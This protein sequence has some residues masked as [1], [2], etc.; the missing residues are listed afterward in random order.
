MARNAKA[1]VPSKKEEYPVKIKFS[2]LAKKMLVEVTL[3]HQKEFNDALVEVY[4]DMNLLDRAES[5][6]EKGES[7]EPQR[8]LSGLVIRNPELEQKKEREEALKKDKEK[9]NG[10]EPGGATK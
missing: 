10:K 6:Q 4:T 9:G 1:G 5:S 8:D 2:K 7:F 3:R